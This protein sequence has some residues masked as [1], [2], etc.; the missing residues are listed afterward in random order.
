MSSPLL[1]TVAPPPLAA[2]RRLRVMVITTTVLAA[3]AVAANANMVAH[4]TAPSGGM[5]LQPLESRSSFSCFST[6]ASTRSQRKPALFDSE[7]QRLSVQ[8]MCLQPLELCS[9]SS[10]SFADLSWLSPR[11]PFPALNASYQH[12]IPHSLGSATATKSALIV[13]HN[14]DNYNIQKESILSI[15]NVEA[16]IQRAATTTLSPRVKLESFDEDS[17]L[18]RFRSP[19]TA[20][21]FDKKQYSVPASP[22][23]P[24]V[25]CGTET[26]SSTTATESSSASSFTGFRHASSQSY[27]E[28]RHGRSLLSS[29]TA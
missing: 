9:S 12:Y 22:S 4:A 26:S 11:A 18:L 28:L 23:Q 10:C 6:A 14:T 5:R 20:A 1:V 8:S 17:S 16:K 27:F 25:P 2:E 3:S 15:D 13:S 19:L 24:R 7:C 21:D 29:S